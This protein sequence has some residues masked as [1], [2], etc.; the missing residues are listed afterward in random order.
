M[1]PNAQ[2]NEPQHVEAGTG[3]ELDRRLDQMVEEG[4]PQGAQTGDQGQQGTQP[5]QQG[6]ERTGTQGREGGQAQ[7]TGQPGQQ[8]GQTPD[9]SQQLTSQYRL[10]SDAQGN[11]VDGQGNIV[12]RAGKERR[13]WERVQRYEHF[14]VPELRKQVEQLTQQQAQTQVLNNVPQQLGLSNEDVLQGMRLIASYKKDPVATINYIL[15]EARAAGHNIQ[16]Q[17]QGRIDLAAVSRLLDERLKPITEDRAAHQRQQEVQA[18]A[19]REYNDFITRFP[20]AVPHEDVIARLLQRDTRL[21]PEAAYYQL[22]L[23]AQQNG[24]NWNQPLQPQV[25]ALQSGNDGAQQQQTMLPMSGGRGGN[26]PVQDRQQAA[27]LADVDA[28]TADIVKEA[29]RE[30]GLNPI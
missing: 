22:R 6:T 15:T 11:L 18:Q 5:A 19:E 14:E 28:D 27:R 30:A 9:P 29:M 8:Q 3:D 21:S 26:A 16:G 17:D 20:D 23:F 7:Q 25:L 12:A 10:G 1:E 4:D 2:G 13:L 24:L